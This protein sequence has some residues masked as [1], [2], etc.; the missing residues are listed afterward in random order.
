LA[1][2]GIALDVQKFLPETK[3]VKFTET[4]KIESKKAQPERTEPEKAETKKPKRT[5]TKKKEKIETK[6]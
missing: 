6:A 3:A 4:F 2:R 1:K 5:P